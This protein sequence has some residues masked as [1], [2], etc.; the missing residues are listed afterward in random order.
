MSMPSALCVMTEALVDMITKAS[1]DSAKRGVLSMWTVY[2]RPRDFP[3]SFVARRFEIGAGAEEPT[4]TADV[5]VANGLEQLHR[6]FERAGLVVI[7][8]S[9]GDE[10][11]IVETWM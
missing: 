7:T 2:E 8:H 9:D 5:V 10:P 1:W 6:A 3:E 11:Q 4:P